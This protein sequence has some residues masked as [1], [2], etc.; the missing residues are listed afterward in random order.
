M[1]LLS[2][3]AAFLIASAGVVVLLIVGWWVCRHRRG[4]LYSVQWLSQL[5]CT[6]CRSQ[7]PFRTL[8]RSFIYTLTPQLGASNS[9]TVQESRLIVEGFH[10]RIVHTSFLS[11]K[12]N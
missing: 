10:S 2:H 3:L 7:M 5:L 1:L 12:P 6:T 8:V 9:M 11:S 4:N